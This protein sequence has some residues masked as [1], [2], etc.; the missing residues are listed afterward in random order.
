MRP[1]TDIA[2]QTNANIF[3][4]DPAVWKTIP[5][6]QFRLSP[7]LWVGKLPG[8]LATKVIESCEPPGFLK[9]HPVRQYAQLYAFGR[10]VEDNLADDLN[11]DQDNRLYT[12][13]AL[14]RIIHP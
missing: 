13:I 4:V 9:F 14:S 10:D 5:N 3:Q 11:W 7:D 1:I 6:E 12:C 8:E 2:L